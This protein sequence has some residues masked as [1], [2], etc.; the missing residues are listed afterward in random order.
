MTRLIPL[1]Y[2]DA[3]ASQSAHTLADLRFRAL[4]SEAQWAQLPPAIRRRFAKRLEDGG[5]IV[6]AGRVTET[7]MSRVGAALAQAARIIGGP[8]P[9]ARDI[10]VPSVVTVTEDFR[11]GGQ[12]WTRLYARRRGFPQVIHSSKR[13]AGPTGLEEH[14]GCGVGMTLTV[15]T[16]ERA[17]IFKSARYF[18]E[19]GRWRAYLPNWLCPGALTVTHAEIAP[20]RFAFTLDIVHPWLGLLIHQYA[21]FEESC[22]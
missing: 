3:R 6:Y 9:T 8:L 2:A 22:T 19:I 12:I 20:T 13:F 17:L 10:D 7:V 14:V 1:Q 4:L 18:L 15:C 21:V 16:T 5:T 11:A